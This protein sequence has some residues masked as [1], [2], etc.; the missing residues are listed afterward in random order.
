MAL[1]FLNVASA[2]AGVLMVYLFKKNCTVRFVGYGICLLPCLYLLTSLMG[3]GSILPKEIGSVF[4]AF[5]IFYFLYAII[6]SIPAIFFSM[7]QVVGFLDK[8]CPNSHNL[9]EYTLFIM[10]WTLLVTMVGFVVC[11]K[12]ER[13]K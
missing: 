2:V 4:L 12:R 6:L 11:K 13:R 9:I 5:G 3:V 7:I 10:F 1:F 8:C